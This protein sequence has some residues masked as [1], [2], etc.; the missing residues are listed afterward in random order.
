MTRVCTVL[1]VK[2]EAKGADPYGQVRPGGYIVLQGKLI[3]GT[4]KKYLRSRI[5]SYSVA[6]WYAGREEFLG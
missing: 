2:C 4:I 1:D 6:V 5:W 3:P